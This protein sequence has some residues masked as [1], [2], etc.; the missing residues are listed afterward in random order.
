[1]MENSLISCLLNEELPY[2]ANKL[3]VI[4]KHASLSAIKDRLNAALQ[5]RYEQP[6]PELVKVEANPN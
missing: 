6:L 3:A 2:D 1:M 4:D 5:G